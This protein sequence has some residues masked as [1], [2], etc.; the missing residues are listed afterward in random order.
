M[1]TQTGIQGADIP[2]LAFS[3]REAA[4]SAGVAERRI[5]KA[6]ADKKL[7]AR[8][9]GKATL[10]EVAELARWISSLPTRGTSQESIAA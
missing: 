6:M 8:K 7:V 4:K 9:D 5:F 3:P 1:D 2:R 10:I